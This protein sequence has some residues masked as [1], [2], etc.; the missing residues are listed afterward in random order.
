MAQPFSRKLIAHILTSLNNRPNRPLAKEQ[1]A[2]RDGLRLEDVIDLTHE[3][4]LGGSV[5][6]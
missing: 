4:N 1:G 2:E 6:R 3:G 5:S